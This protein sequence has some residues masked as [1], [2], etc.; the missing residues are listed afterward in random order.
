[1]SPRKKKSP[2]PPSHTFRAIWPIVNGAGTAETDA[3]LILQALGDLPDVARRHHAT[4]TGTPRA[5][6]TEG[7]LIQGSGGHAHV[8]VIEAP[9]VPM[10]ARNY[11]H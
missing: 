9:A 10:P 11:H 3:D 8:V 4:I 2:P 6:I 5:C 7:R 1:M